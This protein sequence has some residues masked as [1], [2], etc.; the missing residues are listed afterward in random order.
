[1]PPYTYRLNQKTDTVSSC[2]QHFVFA[3]VYV[4]D[5]G[6]AKCLW[7]KLHKTRPLLLLT[8]NVVCVKSVDTKVSVFTYCHI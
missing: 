6:N 4:R 7:L 5:Y 1:M 3:C 8:Y 2:P